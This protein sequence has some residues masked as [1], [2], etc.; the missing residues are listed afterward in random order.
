MIKVNNAV[1]TAVVIQHSCEENYEWQVESDL[2]KVTIDW[3]ITTQNSLAVDKGKNLEGQGCGLFQNTILAFV[4]SNWGKQWKSCQLIIWQRFKLSISQTEVYMS[5]AASLH[6]FA[7]FHLCPKKTMT[8][9]MINDSP[10]NILTR[11][12]PDMSDILLLSK[13]C[14]PFIQVLQ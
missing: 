4:C 3:H 14:M 12:F 13:P 9:N 1:W 11:S 6:Q 8:L 2:K 10:V 5:T 7:W